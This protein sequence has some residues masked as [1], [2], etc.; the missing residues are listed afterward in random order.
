MLPGSRRELWIDVAR[1]I[2]IT[3]VVFAHS[4]SS[5]IDRYRAYFYWTSMPTFFVLSG[6][7][8]RP[9]GDWSSL[10]QWILRRIQRLLVPYL[11]FLLLISCVGY[12]VYHRPY[13]TSPSIIIQNFISAIPGGSYTGGDYGTVWFITCLFITQVIWAIL[14]FR[15]RSVRLL[16]LTTVV[17]YL[18]A[19]LEATAVIDRG[20]KLPLGID[21]V[22]MA[23][24]YYSIGSFL[25]SVNALKRHVVFVGATAS[26]SL[27]CVAIAADVLGIFKYSF[28]MKSLQYSH[29]ILD[30][31]I[32]LAGVV[33][34]FAVSAALARSQIAYLWAFLGRYS[35]PIMYMHIVANTA[36]TYVIHK[37][38]GIGGYGAIMFT[39]I[40]IAVPVGATWMVFERLEVARILFLGSPLFDVRPTRNGLMGQL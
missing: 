23:L 1:G 30:L 33:L 13:N 11:P 29:L 22:L 6:Y 17:S 16:L 32:P 27:L 37:Y 28:D 7:L 9:P 26:V 39:V 5:D 24:P 21:V 8:F 2:G 40:G 4:P 10:W 34:Y 19:H 31:V 12:L 20:I 36:A 38:T 35:M 3:L 14:V 25:R 15:L 18:L